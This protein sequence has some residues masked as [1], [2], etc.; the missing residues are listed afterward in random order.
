MHNIIICVVEISDGFRNGDDSLLILLIVEGV[1]KQSE[2]W[3]A[4]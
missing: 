1:H 2:P 3:L 4:Q